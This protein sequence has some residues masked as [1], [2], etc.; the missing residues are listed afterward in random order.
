[1][2]PIIIL[3]ILSILIGIVIIIFLS[4]TQNSSPTK[5]IV[6]IDCNNDPTPRNLT[7]PAT[8][9]FLLK[10]NGLGSGAYSLIYYSD[11]E[12]TNVI[13][14]SIGPTN[15]NYIQLDIP[16][17]TQGIQYVF[18]CDKVD[19]P[20]TVNTPS[21][22]PINPYIPYLFTNGNLIQSMNIAL[23][24]LNGD[25]STLGPITAGSSAIPNP[26]SGYNSYSATF[27]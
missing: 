1:M 3:L 8:S 13:G 4:I 27:S 26:P 18:L 12:Y 25:P 15:E 16:S 14:N 20:I 22:V 19:I 23:T 11:P 10:T 2:D 9:P 24:Y 17:G 5:S 6:T 7:I 21:P